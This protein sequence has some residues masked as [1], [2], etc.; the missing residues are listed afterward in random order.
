MDY[1]FYEALKD[2]SE[3]NL[4][5]FLNKKLKITKNYLKMFDNM[6]DKESKIEDDQYLIVKDEEN[7]KLIY[8]FDILV[9]EEFL[10]LYQV[11]KINMIRLTEHDFSNFK[12]GGYQIVYCCVS[13]FEDECN[14]LFSPKKLISRKR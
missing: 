3:N 5:K 4:E 6:I 8:I 13:I 12:K 10:P 2:R 9:L 11:N 14:V 1:K 7:D